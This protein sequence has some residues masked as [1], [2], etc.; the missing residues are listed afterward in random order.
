LFLETP[1]IAHRDYPRLSILKDLP[2][3][4]RSI[5]FSDNKD[6][7][8]YLL[9]RIRRCSHGLTEGHKRSNLQD[10]IS[11][12]AKDE[13]PQEMLNEANRIQEL[14]RQYWTCDC[15]TP[16]RTVHL[17]L[18]SLR[19][20]REEDG[21]TK[22]E[23]LFSGPGTSLKWQEGEILVRPAESDLSIYLLDPQC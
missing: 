16:S 14:L 22:F 19:L 8:E 13:L 9:G 7:Q 11:E 3:P 18:A 17:N 2:H 10:F 21:T 6:D 20:P 1:D 5:R 12:A 23:V 4:G 15:T